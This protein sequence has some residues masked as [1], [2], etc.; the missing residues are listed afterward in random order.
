MTMLV[1]LLPQFVVSLSNILHSPPSTTSMAEPLHFFIGGLGG[2]CG[3]RLAVRLRQEFPEAAIAGCVR[4]E[5]RRTGLAL[6]N[7]AVHVLDLDHSYVGLCGSNSKAVVDLE[8]ATHVI[9]TIA[10][11]ADFDRDPLLA[12]H[13]RVLEHSPNLQWVGYLSSTGVYGDHGGAWVDEDADLQCTD[14]K[15]MARVRAEQEWRTLEDH[16]RQQQQQQDENL[17]PSQYPSTRVDCFRC[18]GIY[19]PG[20]GPLSSAL[21]ANMRKDPDTLPASE[22]LSQQQDEADTV[23]KY[24]NRIHVDDICEALI[25]AIKTNIKDPQKWGGSTYNLVDDDPAPRRL[26]VAEANR[27]VRSL[28]LETISSDEAYQ[29][30]LAHYQS[31]CEQQLTFSTHTDSNPDLLAAADYFDKVVDLETNTIEHRSQV[32]GCDCGNLLVALRSLAAVCASL[33]DYDRCVCTVDAIRYWKARKMPFSVEENG[34]QNTTTEFEWIFPPPKNISTI[35]KEAL[36]PPVALRTL[37]EPL[38]DAETCATIQNAA[39]AYRKSL[40]E[41]GDQP[42]ST[43]FT[44]QYPGNSDLHVADLVAH[45]PEVGT[46]F[47]KVLQR[48]LYPLVRSAYL[49]STTTP[50]L[51]LC[52]YDA[53]VVRYDGDEAT[54]EGRNLGASLPLVGDRRERHLC[55]CISLLHSDST[56]S[57][58]FPKHRDGGLF[59][60]NIELESA[61]RA[62][63]T[64]FDNLLDIDSIQGESTDKDASDRDAI[65]RPLGPGHAVAHRSTERHAGAPTKSG[66]RELLVVFLT[67]R[68]NKPGALRGT[69]ARDSNGG[70]DTVDLAGIE[71]AFYLKNL[72]QQPQIPISGVTQNRC[73]EWAVKN[74]PCDGESLFWTG[75]SKVQHA[76]NVFEKVQDAASKNEIKSYDVTLSSLWDEMNEGISALE[77]AAQQVD[78]YCVRSLLFLGSAY[79]SRWCLAT[80]ADP[81]RFRLCEQEELE[82]AASVLKR[83]LALDTVFCSILGTADSTENSSRAT[84]LLQLGEILLLQGQL[85]KAKEVL[86][87]MHKATQHLPAKR[88]TEFRMTA[89]NMLYDA[90][91]AG[92]FPTQDKSERTPLVPPPETQKVAGTPGSTTLPD[93]Q[94]A[95]NEEEVT[96]TSP[97]PQ[98]QRRPVSRNTGNKRCQNQRLK[99]DF[100]WK[101]L[102]P[103]YKEGL[104]R[105]LDE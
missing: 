22:N 6:P 11:I 9:Q 23:P 49:S 13:G 77:K 7:V 4:S 46:V 40:E 103:T 100:A 101:L 45:Q 56:M 105:C 58:L 94:A 37:G 26:V 78:P 19:G 53:L 33:G 59:T 64:F 66:I 71:R 34:Q 84:I 68:P 88:Q 95:W 36:N 47:D 50:P 97:S 25:A 32:D 89:S 67:L 79:S 80:K 102:A 90:S 104:Q 3:S 98:K 87:Q 99:D 69:D 16:R 57:F 75:R 17:E 48:E 70:N 12:W 35:T 60:V 5:A 96:P 91:Q 92:S 61:P 42:Q 73:Y 27:L 10:P 65:L 54:Q 8:R 28:A 14:A 72:V 24:V 93:R 2:Y 85:D 52:V 41:S 21:V 38:I 81:N 82:K 62:G 63:G 51:S 30:G 20:R 74:Y 29:L 44:M 55:K 31:F 1:A 86:K 15:S 83:A 18:G 76:R 43:R 39:Q